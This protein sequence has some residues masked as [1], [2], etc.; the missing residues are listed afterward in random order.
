MSCSVRP[1]RPDGHGSS[2]DLLAAREEQIRVWIEKDGLSIVKI[3]QFLARSG[4]V[5]PY[6]TLH[7]FAVERCVRKVA[8]A[9]GVEHPSLDSADDVE[10]IDCQ[11][12]ARTLS[13]TYG[14]Q[15]TW[16]CPSAPLRRQIDE[17]MAASAADS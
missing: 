1:A 11:T 6:R 3:E 15:P 2:W 13:E 7:R 14:Y 9:T 17:L 4:C 8:Q 12:R 10:I 16:G 5:V